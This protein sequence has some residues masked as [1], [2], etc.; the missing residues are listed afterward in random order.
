MGGPRTSSGTGWGVLVN[1]PGSSTRVTQGG[2]RQSNVEMSS[3][4]GQGDLLTFGSVPWRP[5]LRKGE[6]ERVVGRMTDVPVRR[7][8]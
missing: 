2:L 7:G 5:E 4:S 6:K 3:G 8:F 1:D